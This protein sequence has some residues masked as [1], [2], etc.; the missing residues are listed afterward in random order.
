MGIGQDSELKRALDSALKGEE[1]NQ[2]NLAYCLS[3]KY[4]KVLSFLCFTQL[5]SRDQFQ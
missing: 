5:T 3:Q 1:G 4:E 2:H